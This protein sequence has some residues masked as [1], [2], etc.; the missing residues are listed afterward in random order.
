MVTRERLHPDGSGDAPAAS[1]DRAREKQ[2]ASGGQLDRLLT[3]S[4]P[5]VRCGYDLRGLSIRGVCPECGTP[6]RT[7]ILYRVDPEADA[8]KPIR[9]P[10]LVAAS[11]VVWPSA[12]L[13]AILSLWMPRIAELLRSFGLPVEAAAI[14]FSEIAI[15]ASIV[16]AIALLGL[17]RPTGT[18]AWWKSW[19]LLV[20]VLSYIPITVALWNM[21]LIDR[22]YPNPFLEYTR[23]DRWSWRLLLGAGMVGVF[24]GFRPVARDLVHRCLALRT[25]RVDR[26]TLLTMVVATVVAGLGDLIRVSG[27]NIPGM[28]GEALEILSTILILVGSGF[29][30]IGM[31]ACIV[32]GWRIGE[33]VLLPSPSPRS[34][35]EGG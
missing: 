31:V 33:S 2:G 13:L 12:S 17:I 35:I 30:T 22:S 21:A 4:L 5:C 14:P 6:L 1:G 24:L 28:G 11:L 27:V 32:D 26:Q 3:G 18:L 34:V 19:C 20:G 8:F 15:G 10:K 29:V 7:T 25:G 9:F 23:G 16:A